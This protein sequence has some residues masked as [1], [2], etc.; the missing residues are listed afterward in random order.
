[1]TLLLMSLLFYFNI[2]VVKL[3][4]IGIAFC[5]LIE[6]SPVDFCILI[7][8]FYAISII[9]VLIIKDLDIIRYYQSL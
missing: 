4:N 8:S 7:V 1:M 5:N 2:C 3:Y 9:Y 6:M